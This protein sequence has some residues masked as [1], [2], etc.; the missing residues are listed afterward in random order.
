MAARHYLSFF[1]GVSRNGPLPDQRAL[2]A[3]RAENRLRVYDTRAAMA[4][5]V[6]EDSHADA[7]RRL[8]RRA[9][10]RLLGASRAAPWA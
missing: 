10:T 4:G 5:L 3:V 2:R 7:A 8:W 1:Q 6:D 9:S